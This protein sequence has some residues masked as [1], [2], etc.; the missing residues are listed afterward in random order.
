MK[1]GRWF[2]GVAAGV[3]IALVWGGWAVAAPNCTAGKLC[4]NTCISRDK[5]CHVGSGGGGEEVDGAVVAGVLL[6]TVAVGGLIWLIVALSRPDR[7]ASSAAS[8]S[9]T[10][11]PWAT[12]EDEDEETA[13]NISVAAW[14]PPGPPSWPS[15]WPGRPASCDRA[16]SAD[17]INPEWVKGRAQDRG[18]KI[19]EEPHEAGRG[20]LAAAWKITTP[21]GGGGLLLIVRAIDPVLGAAE[22]DRVLSAIRRDSEWH[23]ELHRTTP[24]GPILLV[25]SRSS[26]HGLRRMLRMM[27]FDCPPPPRDGDPRSEWVPRIDGAVWEGGGAMTLEWAW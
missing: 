15:S 22:V 11:P 1:Q 12:D 25:A 20:V 14:S 5:E 9:S 26:N 27:P 16:L 3:A 4:G 19:E 18:W 13:P 2:S 6:G 23:G 21:D 10:Q 7:G 17:Q 24:D 8:S